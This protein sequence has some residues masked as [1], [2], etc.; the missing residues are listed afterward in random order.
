[1]KKLIIGLGF[2]ARAGKDTVAEY[3]VNN[4][5]FKRYAFADRLKEVCSS[6]MHENAFGDGFKTSSFETS[7]G[8]AMT[9]GQ[10][11]QRAGVAL[12]NTIDEDLWVNIVRKQ[13]E[14]S[15]YTHIVIPDCRFINEGHIIKEMGGVLVRIRRPGIASDLHISEQEGAKINWDHMLVNDGTLDLLN[16]KTDCL[17]ATL[18]VPVND[19]L[20][21]VSS[22]PEPPPAPSSVP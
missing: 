3:L 11:L 15:D 2:Q 19:M 22:I 17:L 20:A 18:G 5:G 13:I 10:L 7:P 4:Y 12:R 1:M 6:L 8:V 16:W 9:G 21:G 14:E